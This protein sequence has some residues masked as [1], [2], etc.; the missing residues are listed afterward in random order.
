MGRDAGEERDREEGIRGEGGMQRMEQ[1]GRR[2]GARG[3]EGSAEASEAG[4]GR[5]RGLRLRVTPTTGMRKMRFLPSA[6]SLS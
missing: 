5:M 6:S 2:G 1:E 3:G 4:T